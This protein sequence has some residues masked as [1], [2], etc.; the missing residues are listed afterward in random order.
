MTIIIAEQKNL[1]QSSRKV[2]LVANQVKKLTLSQAVEQLAL[3]Q[4]KSSL[5]ILKV[6]RQALANA[7]HNYQLEAEQLFL[8]DIVI[9]DGPILKR[10]RAVSRG[11]G[12]SIQKRTCHV[13]VILITADE[14]TKPTLKKVTQKPAKAVV[15]QNTSTKSEKQTKVEKTKLQKTSIKPAKDK[16]AKVKENK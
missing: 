14:K 11:R 9:S 16:K 1:R 2:R 6:C 10:M 5:A 13:K 15:K 4:R 7:S 12:H 8:K 3:I